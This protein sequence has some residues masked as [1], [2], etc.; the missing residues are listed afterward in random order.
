MTRDDIAARI[1]RFVRTEF[2]VSAGDSGFTR[3]GRLFE[4][5]YV[6][7]VGVTELLAFIE[8]T[9]GVA[10]TDDDLLSDRFQTINGIAEIVAWL[11]DPAPR[12]VP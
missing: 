5:G 6:D 10:V 8:T 3:D 1:E 11:R 2:A 7:S 4:L 9:F 12:P